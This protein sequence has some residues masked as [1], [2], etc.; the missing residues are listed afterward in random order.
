MT[1]PANCQDKFELIPYS[2]MMKKEW[3][4]FITL[5]KNATFLLMRDYMD[6][7]TERF[8][9]LSLVFLRNGAIYALL[10]A[11]RSGDTIY[12]HAGLTYAGLIMNAKCT[13][14]GVL[15]IFA[16][17]QDHLRHE[18]IRN[19]IYKPIPHIYHSLP[20]EEDLYALFR[21]GATLS[22]RNIASVISRRHRIK[23]RDIRK[24]GIRKA[25]KSGL[26]VCE[27]SDFKSF[28]KILSDNLDNKYG[29]SPVHSIDEIEK[30]S[31]LFPSNIR[32]FGA[33]LGNEMIAGVVI[34][35]SSRV[36]H[37]QYISANTTGKSLGA[38]DLI[39][40]RLINYIFADIEYFDFGTSN[41]N[42]GK[43]LNSSL[44]YQKEGFG[45]RAVCYD[46]YE[47]NVF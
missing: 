8:S 29:A 4:K 36:A 12:S 45:A 38:L 44:I 22:A 28:W 30:L 5:S 10:P 7:H 19:L 21:S 40:D 24:S 41:E 16:L 3:D 20:A 26:N 46:T 35:L 47:L 6:Y 13:A 15:D 37:C 27:S 42:G 14:S 1:I 34:F 43:I 11:C 31:G 23:F 39:F 33:F 18:G 32:L 25:T 2:P 17:L 9:D